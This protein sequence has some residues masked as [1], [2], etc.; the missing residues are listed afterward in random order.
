MILP[1]KEYFDKQKTKPTYFREKILAS[2]GMIDWV[3]NGHRYITDLNAYNN[4]QRWLGNESN[5]TPG[6]TPKLHTFREGNR[7]KAGDIMHM[8]YGIRTNNYQ[9]FNKWISELQKVKSVQKIEIKWSA[10][11]NGTNIL[12]RVTVYIDD[13][14]YDRLEEAA[15]YSPDRLNMLARNDGFDVN[16]GPNTEYMSFFRWFNKD[17]SGQIIHWTDLRY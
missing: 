13:K 4:E 10:A 2:V 12:K 11:F 7:W 8:A 3:L 9:Q 16:N 6:Y 17:F 14:Q 1:F 5:L 15:L